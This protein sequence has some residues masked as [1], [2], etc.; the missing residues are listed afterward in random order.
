VL[1]FF[2]PTVN[3]AIDTCSWLVMIAMLAII[4]PATQQRGGRRAVS[5]HALGE[6]FRYVWSHPI[7]LSMMLLDFAQ[8]FL[9]QARGLL[10]VYASDVLQ[11]GPQG[12]GVLSA[13]SSI[14]TLSTGAVMSALPHMRRTGLGVLLGITLFAICTCVF[15]YSQLFWLSALMLAGQGAGDCISHVFRLTIL[16]SHIPDEIRGRVTGVNSL[17]T[18]GGG[19]LGQFRAGSMA[20]WLGP[21]ASVL[22]GGLAVLGVIAFVTA[23]P[24][25]RKFELVSHPES[26]AAG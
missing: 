8:N 11:V 18:N 24:L 25:V 21:E 4:H 23:L 17:F 26:V 3:Y 22:A 15:S 16:Q 1:G 13:A 20:Q 7:L 2:G 10:P 19:P 6:G 5:F 14:G 12:L 9:G